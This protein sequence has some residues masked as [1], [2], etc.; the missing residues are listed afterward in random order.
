MGI[1]RLYCKPGKH[2]WQRDSQRGKPPQA[3]S[4][5]KELNKRTVVATVVES[6]SANETE[7]TEEPTS[8]VLSGVALTD[9]LMNDLASRGQLLS[10]QKT[11]V[12]SG[13]R[14]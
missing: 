9:R 6:D 14:Y 8:T 10:Q 2:A 13:P 3:C 4:T 1:Q 7:Q 12:Y 11:H 5:H